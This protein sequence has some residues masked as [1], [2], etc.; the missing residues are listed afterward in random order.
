MLWHVWYQFERE[1]RD[2]PQ[3]AGTSGFETLSGLPHADRGNL[4]RWKITL[5]S[6]KCLN[7]LYSA[8]DL[9]LWMLKLFRIKWFG[10]IYWTCISCLVHVEEEFMHGM[11]STAS[12][13]G[14]VGMCQGRRNFQDLLH[15]LGCASVLSSPWKLPTLLVISFRFLYSLPHEYLCMANLPHLACTYLWAITFCT[16][17]RCKQG[18]ALISAPYLCSEIRIKTTW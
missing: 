8:P 16:L 10:N 1:A 17:G 12:S 13:Q 9:A 18:S 11:V 14:W 5:D 2:I 4:S 6:M 15:A 3:T 7:C